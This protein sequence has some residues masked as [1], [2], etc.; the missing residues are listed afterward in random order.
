M[1]DYE[2]KDLN[3]TVKN[4]PGLDIGDTDKA[5]VAYQVTS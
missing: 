4:Y 2:L 1:Y 3:E 5:L